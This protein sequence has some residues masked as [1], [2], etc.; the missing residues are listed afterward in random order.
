MMRMLLSEL[1]PSILERSWLTMESETPMEE[2]EEE[3]LWW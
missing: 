2:E 1:T 3:E